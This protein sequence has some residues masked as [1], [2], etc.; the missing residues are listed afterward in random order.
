MRYAGKRTDTGE[1]LAGAGGYR[2]WRKGLTNAKLFHR[3]A[4]A[5]TA[6]T[7]RRYGTAPDVMAIVAVAREE[8]E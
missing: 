5:H 7:L 1:F 8:A 4:G 2:M 6:T 3:R